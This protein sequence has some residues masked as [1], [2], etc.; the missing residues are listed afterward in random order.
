MSQEQAKLAESMMNA[1][2]GVLGS[3]LID[4]AAVGPML[5]AVSEDDFR[6]PEQRSVFRAIRE[7]YGEGSGVDAILVNERLGGKHNEYLA[8]LINATPTAANADAYA[9]ELKRASR[10]WQLREIGEALASAENE[11][12][13]QKLFDK[14]NLLFCENQG[15]KRLTMMQ[16]FM[17]FWKR[18]TGSNSGKVFLTWGFPTLDKLARV[19]VGGMG[20]IGG[21]PSA[22]KTALALQFAFHIAKTKSVGFFSYETDN[23]TLYDRML[24]NQTATSF[25]RL[26]GDTLIEG[27]YRRI[28]ASRE[29]LTSPRL[30]FIEASGWTVK[31]I[32]AYSMAQHYDVIFID[33]LQKIPEP[34][35]R[36]KF[37]RVG[38]VSEQIQRFARRTGK[39]VIALSQLKRTDEEK[40]PTMSDLRESGQ[41]EQDADVI[42]LLYLENP[43][44]KCGR[45]V[46]DI[47]KNKNGEPG[48]GILL[49]FHGDTQTFTKAGSDREE[50]DRKSINEPPVSWTESYYQSIH[51]RAAELKE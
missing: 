28:R 50:T 17:E 6:M 51:D 34:G 27:D 47:A 9:R 40:A 5:M 3:M 20:I 1:A 7:L 14:G 21:R 49:D 32:A 25:T 41:I 35:V 45:R 48:R 16:G 8:G 13:A 37:Q 19:G 12:E 42:M 39:T 18:K 2:V 38:E 33:Y 11:E 26:M 44:D 23:D 46:L 36:D 31:G 15:V 10:L 22:G 30:N 29:L 43:K 24:A 4:E